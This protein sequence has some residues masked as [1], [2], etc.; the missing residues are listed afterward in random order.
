MLTLYLWVMLAWFCLMLIGTLSTPRKD[1]DVYA[2]C[3]YTLFATWTVAMLF[4]R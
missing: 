3:I 2:A 4:T 1:H